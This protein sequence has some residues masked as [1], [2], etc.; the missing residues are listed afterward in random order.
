MRLT[1]YLFKG[2]ML[3]TSLVTTSSWD[4]LLIFYLMKEGRGEGGIVTSCAQPIFRTRRG[5][6]VWST[7]YSVFV[8]CGLKI[9]DVTSLKI[10][11]VMSH[12]S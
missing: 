3:L 11:Y 2:A 8:P 1:T 9:G 12:K 5:K 6:I 10:Y 7:A 4:W